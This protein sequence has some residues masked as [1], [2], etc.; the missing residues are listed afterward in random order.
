MAKQTIAV[1]L[2]DVL[3]ASA[4]GFIA[5]SNQKWGTNLTVENYHENWA[6]MWQLDHD[7]THERWDHFW[8]SGIVGTFEQY[9]E[10]KP[11]LQKL[12]QRFRLVIATARHR[13]VQKET[14]EWLDVH[15]KDVFEEVHMAGFYEKSD[16]EAHKLTKADLLKSIRADYVIDDQPKHC[17]AAADVGISA[18]LFGDYSWNRQVKLTDGVT[19]ARNWQEVAE[20]FGV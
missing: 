15:H 17:L 18:V 13:I 10:A 11:V 9:D 16:P 4:A 5:Y 1:D 6:E 8:K 7:A 12:K 19:R 2:D 14:L 20:Y 3:S